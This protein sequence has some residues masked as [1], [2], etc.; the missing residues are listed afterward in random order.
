MANAKLFSQVFTFLY[1]LSI[2]IFYFN[3][4]FI[5][6]NKEF[7][8][9]VQEFILLMN[10]SYQFIQFFFCS[11]LRLAKRASKS[12]SYSL[13]LPSSLDV[14][15]LGV[16]LDC[17][18]FFLPSLAMKHLW[19]RLGRGGLDGDVGGVLVGGGVGGALVGVP[20]S[21]HVGIAALLLVLLLLFLFLPFLVVAPITIT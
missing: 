18:L 13:E 15:Y 19:R 1:F 14:V 8:L 7:L 3:M 16:V 5:F 20:F 12:S 10:G 11:M 2:S 21:T 6:F 17:T 4:F 9:V